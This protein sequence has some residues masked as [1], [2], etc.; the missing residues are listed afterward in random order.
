MKDAKYLPSE[1]RGR[2]ENFFLWKGKVL[3]LAW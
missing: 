2:K 1:Y 3:E